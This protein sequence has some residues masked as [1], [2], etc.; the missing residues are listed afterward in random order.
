MK[1][2]KMNEMRSGEQPLETQLKGKLE[3]L[4]P[5]PERDPQSVSKG[6][7]RFLMEL[8]AIPE[9]GSSSRLSWLTGLFKSKSNQSKKNKM[10]PRNQKFALTTVMAV[11]IVVV[12]LFSGASATA[13]AS[14]SALPGDALYPVKTTLEQT[15]IALARDAY[16]RA[17]LH[18][19]FA[20]IRIDEIVELLQQ[21]RF[22]DVELASSEFEYY[23]QN[24]MNAL[25][26]V[27][28]GDPARGA[29]LSN[30]VTQ[31]LLLYT[32]KLQGILANTP[33]PVRPAVERVILVSEHGAGEEMEI[34]GI[35]VSI[36]DASLELDSVETPITLNEF[37]E[38]KDMISQGDTVKVHVFVAADGTL[39][40]DEIELS[41]SFGDDDHGEDQFS[42]DDDGDGNDNANDDNGNDNSDDDGNDKDDDG[43]N[44]NDDDGGNDNADDDG[45]ENGDDDGNDNG[46]DDGN[47][48]GDDDNKNGNDNDEEDD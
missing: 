32:E 9:F 13:Y 40:A 16:F 48:N 1:R 36:S 33:E 26:I 7:E 3:L 34:I 12:M 39:I 10:R 37:T 38:I 44:D 25:Q 6:R 18:L 2:I 29:D 22:H 31:I 20:Q 21:D 11:V 23:I 24:V 19:Q 4:R 46:D 47:N 14:Q 15:R 5:T 43:G 30:Q 45:N 42:E 41:D 27:L 35:V 17:Q 28:A 8:D